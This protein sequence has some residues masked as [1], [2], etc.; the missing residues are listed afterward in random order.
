[1]IEGMERISVQVID[2]DQG[3]GRDEIDVV[4]NPT[5]APT[6]QIFSPQVGGSY[7]SDQ[8]ILFAAEISDTEDEHRRPNR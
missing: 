8:L 1:M 2:P 6:A 5:D 4:V 3:A 7:Y